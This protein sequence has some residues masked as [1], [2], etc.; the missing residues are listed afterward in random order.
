[1][2]FMVLTQVGGWLK[3]P[4]WVFGHVFNWLYELLSFIGIENVAVTVILFTIVTKLLMTPLTIKQQ[5]FSRLSNKMQPELSA[6]QEK[7]KGKKDEKSLRLQQMETQAVY[8]KYGT[9]PSSGCLPMLITL[10]I[11]FALYRVIYAIPAYVDDIYVLYNSI[12]EGLKTLDYFPYMSEMATT[13]GVATKNFA[14]MSESVLTNDHLIDIMTKFGTEEW[15]ALAAQFPSITD[16]ISTNVEQITAIHSV[17]KFNIL[18][19]PW[20]YRFSPALLIPVLAT[21][22]QLLS[23][24]LSM[25]GQKKKDLSDNP[26]AQSMNSMMYTMPFMSGFMCLMFP[27]CIG[28]Y[29]VASTVVTTIYQLVINKYIDKMDLNEM[30]QKNVEKQ[31]KKKEKLGIEYGSKMAELAKTQTK[32]INVENAYTKEKGTAS[33]YANASSKNYTSETTGETKV[34]VESKSIS[35]YANMLKRD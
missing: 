14:E 1:V 9:N 33:S 8:D 35:G 10:P 21:V 16:I 34:N 26:M 17:G 30:I 2:N 27:I 29:W 22:T 28:I 18:D 20:D 12:A 23:S 13:L 25:A 15:T 3:W 31:N 24:K 5:K 32:N 11:M 6:I 4:A 7:Y 19:T